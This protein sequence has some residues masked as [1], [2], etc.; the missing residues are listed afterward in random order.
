MNRKKAYYKFLDKFSQTYP[1]GSF[2]QQVAY[3]DAISQEWFVE[4]VY[5][6]SEYTDYCRDTQGHYGSMHEI[7][8]RAFEKDLAS[9][10][11][12]LKANLEKG[13]T[14]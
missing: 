6:C 12:K 3:E 11:L 7:A 1:Q 9:T 4:M 10:Y 5:D 13:P 14:L 8:I 2:E